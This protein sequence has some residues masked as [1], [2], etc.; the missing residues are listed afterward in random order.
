M[1][2]SF[3]PTFLNVYRLHSMFPYPLMIDVCWALAMAMTSNFCTFIG[4][5]YQSPQR[6]LNRSHNSQMMKIVPSAQ[7]K[8]IS[9]CIDS[10]PSNLS[11]SKWEKK[12]EL[13]IYELNWNFWLRSNITVTNSRPKIRLVIEPRDQMKLIVT[14]NSIT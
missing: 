11:S 6:M 1:F 3:R 7:S 4:N 2:N 5:K 13:K 10:T 12:S 9:N 8:L 14:L